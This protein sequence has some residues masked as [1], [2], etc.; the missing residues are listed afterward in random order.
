MCRSNLDNAELYSRPKN[1]E[2]LD[3]RSFRLRL[4]VAGAALP[5]ALTLVYLPRAGGPAFVA[6][7]RVRSEEGTAAVFASSDRVRAAEG[8][9]FEAYVGA[10][11]AVRGVFRK[12]GPEWRVECRSGEAAVVSGKAEVSVSA[13]GGIVLKDTVELEK[14]GGRRRRKKFCSKLAEIP[15]EGEELE[16]RCCRDSSEEEEQEWEMVGGGVDGLEMEGV[17]WAV[18]MGIWAVCVGVGLLVSKASY[19]GFKRKFQIYF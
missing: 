7:D 13:S 10:E 5:E 2:R 3:V 8:V 4:S 1:R 11:A 15:E 18:D 19:K 16:C 17:K 6:L 12:D 14:M 9:R